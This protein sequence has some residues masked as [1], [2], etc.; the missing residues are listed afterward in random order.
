MEM[1]VR[2]VLPTI[3]V[4]TLVL[5]LS[6]D[7]ACSVE[8]G[9]YI[10]KHIL[11]AKLVE[12]PGSDHI[13]PVNEELT[14]RIVR[15]IEGFVSGL[16]SAVESDRIL[17][18]VMFKDIVD[19]TKKAVQ[20]GD[21]RWHKLLQDRNAMVRSEIVKFRGKEVKTTGDGVL[22]T[23]DGPTRAIKCALAIRDTSAKLGLEVRAGLHTGEC[24]KSD[25]DVSGIAVH[26][27]ARIVG[28]AGAGEVLVSSTVKDL[29]AGSGLELSDKGLYALKGMPEKWRLFSARQPAYS[30][31]AEGIRT[32]T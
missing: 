23:F 26:L 11:G 15:E 8:E 20:L 3:H 10:A 27:T 6:E 12:I 29:V 31:T 22:A 4:P 17:A 18:T 21:S 19:S 7:R 13:F 28:E 14:D 30:D 24:V 25:N 5:H 1:D 2:H 16:A 32:I 9:R